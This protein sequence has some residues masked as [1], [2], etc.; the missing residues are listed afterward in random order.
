MR[1]DRR[2]GD[3]IDEICE[4]SAYDESGSVQISGVEY[5]AQVDIPGDGTAWGTWNGEANATHAQTPLGD[6]T[7]DGAC[8]VGEKARVCARALSP[9][10][11]KRARAAW[12]TAGWLRPDAPFYWQQCLGADG[13]LEPGAPI[14]LHPCE[15]TRDRIFERGA[16]STLTI[17]DR[18]DLCLDLEGPGM[19]KPPI[20]ILNTCDAKSARFVLAGGKDSSGAIKAP[21]GLCSTIPGTEEDTGSA[22]YQVVMQPCD[23]PGAKVMEFDF[24]N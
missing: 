4:F 6:L 16:D 7:R 5:F 12:P 13:P 14:V 1:A 10:A 2:R 15:N 21:G 8:W 18:P 3:Y 22:P 17:A 24:T 20:L 23:D 9:E 19:M 11:E